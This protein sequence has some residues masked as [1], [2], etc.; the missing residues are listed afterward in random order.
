MSR[1]DTYIKLTIS[2]ETTTFHFT[3]TSIKFYTEH[4]FKSASKTAIE[5]KQCMNY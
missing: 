3:K 1:L 2:E 5:P 4:Q